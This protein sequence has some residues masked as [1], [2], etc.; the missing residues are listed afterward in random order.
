M[1]K[2]NKNEDDSS[3]PFH[4]MLISYSIFS[5]LQTWKVFFFFPILM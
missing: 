5:E 1:V 2:K 4:D 3:L